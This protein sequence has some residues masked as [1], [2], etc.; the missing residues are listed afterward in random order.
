MMFDT[1]EVGQKNKQTDGSRNKP[2]SIYTFYNY[3]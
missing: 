2:Y 1:T 3:I